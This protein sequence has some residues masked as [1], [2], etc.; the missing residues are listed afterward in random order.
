ML[1]MGTESLVYRTARKHVENYARESNDLMKAHQE[2]MDCREC[3]A[4]LQLGIDAFRWIIRAD[5]VIRK[6]IYDRILEFDAEID[7]G[8][9]SMCRSWLAPCQYAEQ[10]IAKQQERGYQIDNLGEFRECCEEMRA[11]VEAQD[12]GDG[13]PL[14][15][16]MIK[17]RD[18]A[19]D[20]YRNGETPEFV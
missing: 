16:A 13:E 1:F 3:E 15:I 17:L 10:W 2:A 18:K 20:E 12:Q 7:D 14:P 19:I 9:R 11:I 4:F 6:A 5:R 8:I